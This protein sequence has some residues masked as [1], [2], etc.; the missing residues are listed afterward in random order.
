MS[1]NDQPATPSAIARAD[2][3][4]LRLLSVQSPTCQYF[5]NKSILITGA[6]GFCGK[7][8]LEKIVRTMFQ[9]QKVYLLLRPGSKQ[10]SVDERLDEL[11]KSAAFSFNRYEK[12]QFKKIVAVQGDLSRPDLGLSDSDRRTLSQN[13][14]IVYHVAAS[15]KF[16]ASFR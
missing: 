13:V 8:L 4:V 14:Q 16:D 11:L 2:P 10:A 7:V 9:V 5:A 12:N 15:I 1:S 3:E 6:T